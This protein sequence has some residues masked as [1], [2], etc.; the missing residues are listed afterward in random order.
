MIIIEVNGLNETF[1]TDIL[2]DI[3]LKE[4]NTIYFVPIH[5]ETNL[6]ENIYCSKNIFLIIMLMIIIIMLALFLLFWN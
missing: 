2:P 1:E 4:Y 5:K 3:G 6:I